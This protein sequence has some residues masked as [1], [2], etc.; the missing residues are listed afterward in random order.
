[1][2]RC[3]H[4]QGNLLYDERDGPRGAIIRVLVCLLCG[5]S[6]ADQPHGPPPKLN[7]HSRRAN[8]RL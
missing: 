8:A 6:E 1:M 3:P 2:P 5:R 7:Q 4:C